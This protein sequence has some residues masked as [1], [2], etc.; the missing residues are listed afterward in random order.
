MHQI[1][2]G[3]GRTTGW[4]KHI[5][6]NYFRVQRSR[7]FWETDPEI[8][9]ACL[10]CPC[11]ALYKCLS[12]LFR[13]MFGFSYFLGYLCLLSDPTSYLPG[14]SGYSILGVN[15]DLR[16]VLRRQFFEYMRK[17]L[18]KHVLKHLE[19]AGSEQKGSF[20]YRERLTI[21]YPFEGLWLVGTHFRR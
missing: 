8:L 19:A 9:H 6:P 15:Y 16:L 18:Y 21:I 3:A 13:Q 2:F 20:F 4:F 7:R 14:F 11:R 12:F 1:N 10:M 17:T 5:T